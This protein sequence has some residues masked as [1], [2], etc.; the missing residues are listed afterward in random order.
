ML[1]FVLRQ[2]RPRVDG[3][4][5]RALGSVSVAF[6]RGDVGHRMGLGL[7]VKR[8]AVFGADTVR[9]EREVQ[10]RQNLPDTEQSEERQQRCA[11]TQTAQLL[12]RHSCH[13]VNLGH[14]SGP[15]KTDRV[16]HVGLGQRAAGPVAHTV[17]KP[18][19][20]LKLEGRIV[21]GTAA[22]DNRALNDAQPAS[23]TR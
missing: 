18:H 2:R 14:T 4:V 13:R 1:V 15:G 22:L 5:G 12:P 16:G 6:T 3:D 21:R 17:R 7:Y 20:L 10:G 19:W 23:R 8:F 9:H 11:P